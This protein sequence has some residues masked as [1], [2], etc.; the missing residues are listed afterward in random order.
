M[1]DNK[2]GKIDM[3]GKFS[4][5]SALKNVSVDAAG[6]VKT[7]FGEMVT[8]SVLGTAAMKSNLEM[9]AMMG[10]KFTIP[11]DLLKIIV[12]DFKSSTFD[13]TPIVYAKD[14]PF[15]RKVIR[16]LFPVNEEIQSA[17]DG[18]SLGTLVLPQKHN[19]Y[20]ML[21][22]RVPLN[23]DADYQSFVSTK[24]KIGLVSVDGEM[25]NTVINAYIEV[26]MPTNDDD[27]LYVYIKSPSQMYYFFGYKQGILNLV[28]NNTRF[29]EQ[30]LK[31]KDKDKIIKLPDGETYEIQPVEE[32]TAS[33]FLN[34]IEAVKKD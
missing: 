16:Q 3:E 25:L 9:E 33:A 14:M 7:T 26:K 6:Y 30:L 22:D 24:S 21:F 34:R 23:W 17:I 27:R 12:S 20:T 2:T 28:S 8:D 13:A 15:Y 11:S 1:Y 19:K 5:G 31:M 32:S 18:I 29:M 10:L 4:L